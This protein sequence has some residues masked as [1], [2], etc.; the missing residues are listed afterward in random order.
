MYGC[1]YHNFR[2]IVHLETIN[3]GIRNGVG[4]HKSNGNQK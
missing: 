4:E 3:E 2:I 1:A